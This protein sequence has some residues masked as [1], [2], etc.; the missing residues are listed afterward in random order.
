MHV[1]FYFSTVNE[2]AT[3]HS[4]NVEMF[5][6]IVIQQLLVTHEDEWSF[7]N[8]FQCLISIASDIFPT[9]HCNQKVNKYSTL[10]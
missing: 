4:R 10:G 3:T 9:S 6:P 5:Y 1:W 2:S 7:C 8:N